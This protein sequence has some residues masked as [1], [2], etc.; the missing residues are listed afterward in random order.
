MVTVA[1]SSTPLMLVLGFLSVHCLHLH[2]RRGTPVR[3][4]DGMRMASTNCCNDRSE[5]AVDG[6]YLISRRVSLA[7]AVSTAV[8]CVSVIAPAAAAPPRPLGA[9]ELDFSFYWRNLFGGK[10]VQLPSPPSYPA[11]RKIETTLAVALLD[12]QDQLISRSAGVP[13]DTLRS[14]A[15]TLRNKVQRYFQRCATAPHG[16]AA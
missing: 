14:N 10:G 2:V 11:P 4:R 12:I 5:A 8:A 9:A 15:S 13:L 7:S 3:L 6:A 1:L 16:S